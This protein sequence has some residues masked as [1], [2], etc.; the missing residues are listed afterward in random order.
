[1]VALWR[2]RRPPAWAQLTLLLCSAY[3]CCEE[4]AAATSPAGALGE[5]GDRKPDRLC[6]DPQRITARYAARRLRL[7]G[8]QSEEQGDSAITGTLM[9]TQCSRAGQASDWVHDRDVKWSKIA[10]LKEIADRALFH[11]EGRAYREDPRFAVLVPPSC[12]VATGSAVAGLPGRRR[13]RPATL[14]ARLV[15]SLAPRVPNPG[16]VGGRGG[17]P[18]VAVRRGRRGFRGEHRRGVRD[19]RKRLS[20]W[21]AGGQLVSRTRV[22]STACGMS[23]RRWTSCCARTTL[24]SRIGI[25][26]SGAFNTLRPFTT[27]TGRFHPTPHV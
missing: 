18:G 25:A 11:G 19:T 26:A 15:A 4:A 22:P 13:C 2:R 24:R 21:S 8:T 10:I 7:R 14:S 1:M 6:R 23:S 3:F 9:R 20:C 12:R 17:S 27:H 5:S 16:G